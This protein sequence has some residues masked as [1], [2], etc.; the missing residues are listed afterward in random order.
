MAK[1]IFFEEEYGVNLEQLHSIEEIDE[2]IEKKSGKK[3]TFS[4]RKCGIIDNTGNV[5]PILSRDIDE[6]INARL[7]R[8]WWK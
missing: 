1:T 5:F 2:V 4:N 7:R 3:L 6:K 8:R